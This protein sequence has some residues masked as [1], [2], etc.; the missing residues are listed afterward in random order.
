MTIRRKRIIHQV[1]WQVT[2]GAHAAVLGANGSGKSTLLRL[3]TGYLYPT[4]G[5]VT[6]LGFVSGRSNVHDLRQRIGLVDPGNSFAP[7][8]RLSVLDLVLTGFWGK[9]CLDF[10]RPTIEQVESARETMANVGLEGKEQQLFRTL[11]TGESRRALLA[12]AMVRQPD[13]LILDEPT[14]GLDLLARE[15]MLATIDRLLDERTGLTTLMV[16]HHVEE[17]SP[18]TNE[19]LLLRDGSVI[20][21]GRPDDVLRSSVISEAFGCQVTVGRSDG[22]WQWHVSPHL[23]ETLLKK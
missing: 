21:C 14:A 11:S 6:T 5:R 10:D 15:T 9:L 18:K 1:S 19:V 17:L 7:D 4:T 22:R 8:P 3:M 12:R 23:W 16:T 2:T 13:L 20:S